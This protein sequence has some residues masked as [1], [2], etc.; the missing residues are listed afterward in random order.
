MSHVTPV[1]KG[2]EERLTRTLSTFCFVKSQFPSATPQKKKK[3][4]MSLPSNSYGCLP[5]RRLGS[6]TTFTGVVTGFYSVTSLIFCLVGQ[7]AE[8]S[9]DNQSS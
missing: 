8:G 2:G 7:M 5:K 6:D 4:K 3:K 9:D 1:E